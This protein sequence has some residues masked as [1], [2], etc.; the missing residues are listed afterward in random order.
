MVSIHANRFMGLWSCSI[1]CWWSAVHVVK[2]VGVFVVCV[3]MGG[4]VVGTSLVQC[5]IR[6]CVSVLAL[7]YST[8]IPIPL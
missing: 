4:G 2:V 7:V 1:G 8:P 6:Q 3:S 5:C